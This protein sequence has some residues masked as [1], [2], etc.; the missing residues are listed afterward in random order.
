MRTFIAFK[1][2]PQEKLVQLIN[3]FQ[4]SLRGEA[5]KWVDINNLHLT[6]KFTG[7][8][9]E[10]Q[11][12][13]ISNILEEIAARYPVVN[14]K[15]RG[16][17]YFKNNS[18]PSVLFLKIDENN[19]LINLVRDINTELEKIGFEGESGRYKPHLTLA[20]IKYLND[21]STFYNLTNRFKDDIIQTEEIGHIIFYQSIL[22]PAGADYRE[23]TRKKLNYSGK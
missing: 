12:A 7:D 2:K 17:G 19:V 1:I 5:I 13:S 21:K 22:K 18:Q 14:L 8:T 23:L 3:F 4:G 16:V 9:S 20:R 11:I 6:L 15:F 10:S